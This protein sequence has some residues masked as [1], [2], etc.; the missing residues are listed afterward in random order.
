[1]NFNMN[2]PMMTLQFEHQEI[3]PHGPKNKKTKYAIEMNEYIHYTGCPR[4]KK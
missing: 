1:M 2:T 3:H 4:Q